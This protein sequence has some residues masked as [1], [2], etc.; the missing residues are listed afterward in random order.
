VKELR[1]LVAWLRANPM[2]SNFGVPA[3]GS[4]PH[5]FALM[6]SDAAKVPGQVIGYRGSAPLANDLIGGAIPVAVDTLDSLLP[7]HEAGKLR[8]LAVSSA[9]RS[10]LAPSLPTFKEGGFDVVANGWNALFAPSSMAPARVAQIGNAVRDAMKDKELQK[11]FTDAKM[12]PVSS[13]PQQT[14]AML[15]AYREQWIPVVKRSGFKP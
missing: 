12:L 3:T 2:Q 4:L 7:L 6:F 9:K 5:F 10:P 15:K 1:H 13:S 14:E 11:R 8:I